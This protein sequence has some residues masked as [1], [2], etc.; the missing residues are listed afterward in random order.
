MFGPNAFPIRSVISGG[1]E[2][3]LCRR[4][5]SV[6][7]NFRRPRHRKF[8]SFDDFSFNQFARMRRAL[9]GS[10]ALQSPWR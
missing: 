9:H 8:E 10:W 3:L 4:S 2:A 5:E 6:A 7:R 1:S